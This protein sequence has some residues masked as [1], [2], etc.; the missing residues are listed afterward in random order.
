LAGK[1]EK[2]KKRPVV[3]PSPKIPAPERIPGGRPLQPRYEKPATPEGT[4]GVAPSKIEQVQPKPGKGPDR[5][6]SGH[7]VELGEPAQKKEEKPKPKVN[8]KMNLLAG[9]VAGLIAAG[10]IAGV[11]YSQGFFGGGGG[12][13]AQ[14]WT[15]TSEGR[16]ATVTV[17]SSGKFSGSGWTGV[18]PYGGSYSI[19]ITGGTMYGTTMTFTANASYDSGQGTISGTGL[20]TMNASF[21]NATSATGT[22]AYTI[23]DPLGTSSGSSNWTATRVS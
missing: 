18:S 1:D 20:G 11:F 19:P 2:R 23:S 12:G 5:S 14:T 17:D 15:I 21:P 22:Y 4:T 16:V 7:W 6:L 3:T 13:G 10:V 9:L 8:V